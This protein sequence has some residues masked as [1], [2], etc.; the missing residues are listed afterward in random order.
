MQPPASELSS[1][2]KVTVHFLEP[3]PDWSPFNTVGQKIH[4]SQP[5]GVPAIGTSN[6]LSTVFDKGPTPG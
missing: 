1:C 4:L 3:L 5:L 6:L 2:R